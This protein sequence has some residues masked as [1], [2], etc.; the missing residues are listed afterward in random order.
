MYGG[1]N[2]EIFINTLITKDCMC[3][4]SELLVIYSF[5]SYL[6]NHTLEYKVEEIKLPLEEEKQK[7]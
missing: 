1:R 3:Q 4:Y 2:S 6:P 7:Y 5:F